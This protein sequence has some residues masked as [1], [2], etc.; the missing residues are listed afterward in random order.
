M[1]CWSLVFL[2][3]TCLCALLAVAGVSGLF[4][5]KWLS[6]VFVIA[7]VIA[8]YRERKVN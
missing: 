5:W 6:G 8:W 2:T 4:L 1:L 7:F 3:L